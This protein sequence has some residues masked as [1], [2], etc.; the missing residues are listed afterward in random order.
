MKGLIIIPA[1][2]EEGSI[3]SLLEELRGSLKPEQS[4][5]VVDDGSQDQTSRIV[6]EAGFA[7]CSLPANLGYAGALKTG[8]AFGLAEGFDWMA[9]MDADGQHRP[10]DL[11]SMAE[12]F[13]AGDLDLLLA[14]RWIGSAQ[15]ENHSSSGRKFG[16][17]FFSWL[18]Q[19]LTG[20]RFTD[21]T[22]GMKLM[23]PR[24]AK[25]L[26]EHNF[27]DLHAEVLIYLHDRGY[28]IDEHPA[29]VREREAGTSMYGFKDVII[30][31]LKNLILIAVYKL[32]S[33]TLARVKAP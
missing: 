28:R 21:T 3:A 12:R 15:H 16:M 18:S 2:N 14:S 29:V 9:F 33:W 24:V 4:V 13:S 27:G 8:L 17:E 7:C 31:P 1:Y 19:R 30:Y 25:E 5:L 22:N 10:E 26:L 32:N 20:R 23:A 6:G 11:Q